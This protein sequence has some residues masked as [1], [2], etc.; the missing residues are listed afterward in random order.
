MEAGADSLKTKETPSPAANDAE[1]ASTAPR[2]D[3]TVDFID[4]RGLPGQGEPLPTIP[5]YDVQRFVARG[6]MG[7]VL[8][9]HHLALDR[10]VA[11][12]LPLPH[13]VATPE[14][15]ERFLREG[16]AAAQLRNANICPIHDVGE[17]DGR[18]YISM[19]YIEGQTLK[20]W[21][22]TKSPNARQAAEMV[23]LLARAVYYA[24][25]HG[26]VHRDLKPS[27]A[28][29]DAETNQPVLMDFGLAKQLTDDAAGMTHTGQVMGT[30]AYMA[31]EQAA[32]R[33]D[34]IGTLSDVYSL[35]A[36]L[37]ELLCGRP[38]FQG[39]VGSVLKQVQS[40]E[41]A[42]PRQLALRVHRDLETICLK[43]LRKEPSRRYKSALE[44]A[45]DLERFNAGL[46]IVAKREGLLAKTWRKV[47]R[48]PLSAAVALAA[49]LALAVAG[50]FGLYASDAR[51]IAQLDQSF[52]VG[53]DSE[54]WPPQHLATMQELIDS[55]RQL[56]P[57]HA[58]T[59]KERLSARYADFHK[60]ALRVDPRLDP[61]EVAAVEAAIGRLDKAAP[62][63]A[64]PLRA[65]LQD[66]L[67][68]WDTLFELASGSK[69]ES[70][71]LPGDVTPSEAGFKLILVWRPTTSQTPTFPRPV[72]APCGWNP[73]STRHGKTPA[74]SDCC[75]I[76]IAGTTA[77]SRASPSP[78]AARWRPAPTIRSAFWSGTPQPARSFKSF[79]GKE[80]AWLR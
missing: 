38:P 9:A 21:A 22:N 34:E 79:L 53:L 74:K 41:P 2:H 33:H 42:T 50:Y 24:H 12:K 37:Y 70:V 68:R 71:F 8:A 46:A 47:H 28:M 52:E 59:A 58:A 4:V 10:K 60:N 76:P 61:D 3:D 39:S 55:L 32:G 63:H 75:S 57:Q 27:N 29:V 48:S 20:E 15:R 14:D 62:S 77:R 6:G 80:A 30:P 51:R 31:P 40:E 18:P 25:E 45:E 64:A 5:G 49:L 78:P 35:G 13:Q 11:I 73:S 56:D 19:A 69:P 7:V 72:K 65:A 26:V 17:V 16:R 67:R 43:A 44:L 54:A 36:I 23:A 66:R 1:Q